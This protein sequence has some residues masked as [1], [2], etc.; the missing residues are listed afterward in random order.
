MIAPPTPIETFLFINALRYHHFCA[1]D[2]TP[3]ATRVIKFRSKNISVPRKV[4]KAWSILI[5]KFVNISFSGA[6]LSYIL[7][8]RVDECFFEVI[9]HSNDFTPFDQMKTYDVADAP[10]TLPHMV[11]TVVAGRPD[12]VVLAFLCLYYFF[13]CSLHETMGSNQVDSGILGP[14]KR[15]RS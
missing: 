12:D 3:H 14:G 15:E 11:S 10:T 13:F 8:D 4:V 6:V 7:F 1:S 5:R 9:I 2:M